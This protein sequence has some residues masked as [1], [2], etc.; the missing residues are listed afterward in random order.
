MKGKTESKELC[1][2]WTTSQTTHLGTAVAGGWGWGGAGR[3]VGGGAGITK[4]KRTHFPPLRSAFLHEWK[5][6]WGSGK[7]VQGLGD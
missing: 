7:Y 1:K 6:Q 4:E 2:C 3:Q 5:R